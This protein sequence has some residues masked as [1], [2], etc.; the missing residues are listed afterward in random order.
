MAAGSLPGALAFAHCIALGSMYSGTVSIFRA[1]VTQKGPERSGHL[2][3]FPQ[4][5]NQEAGSKL[6]SPAPETKH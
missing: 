6:S 4:P 1:Q 2:F 5:V 3:R